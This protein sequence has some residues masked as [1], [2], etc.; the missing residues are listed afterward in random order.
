MIDNSSADNKKESKMDKLKPLLKIGIFLTLIYYLIALFYGKHFTLW[1]IGVGYFGFIPVFII[2]IIL[3]F[4]IERFQNPLKVSEF[5][6]II[7]FSIIFYTL[8]FNLYKSATR[9]SIGL[10]IFF[11]IKTR[12]IEEHFAEKYG[13]EIVVDEMTYYLDTGSAAREGRGW[14]RVVSGHTLDDPETS[15]DIWGIK[16]RIS[17]NYSSIIFQKEVKDYYKDILEKII[18]WEFRLETYIKP[19][20]NSYEKSYKEY[21]REEDSEVMNEIKFYIRS[22]GEV[23]EVYGIDVFKEIYLKVV[24][25]LYTKNRYL[26]E[27]TIKFEILDLNIDEIKRLSRD[28]LFETDKELYELRVFTEDLD[29]E[30]FRVENFEEFEEYM[31]KR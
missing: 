23:L 26:K 1:F 22:P 17:D 28:E 19:Y 5:F 10:K 11:P 29:E 21:L 15:I 7:V 4:I 2:L 25:T 27:S 14:Y 12:E 6:L 18:P 24:R 3:Y 20:R 30:F 13:A 16:G 31:K 9:T 8:I